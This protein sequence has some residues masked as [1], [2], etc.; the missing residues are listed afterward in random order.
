MAFNAGTPIESPKIYTGLCDFV[1]VAL[2]P[3]K[4]ELASLGINFEKEPSYLDKNSEGNDRIRLDFWGKVVI[5]EVISYKKVTFFIENVEKESQ[6]GNYQ[7]I[8]IYGDSAWGKDQETVL[9]SYSWFKANGVRKAKSGEADFITFIKRWL[10]IGRGQEAAI[11]NFNKLFSGNVDDF[12]TLLKVNKDRKLQVLLTVTE[13][14]DKYYQNIYN[15]YFGIAG[16]TNHTYWKK[17]FDS[18]TA[19]VNY[20]NSFSIKEFTGINNE[21]TDKSSSESN[22]TGG[23]WG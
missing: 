17:H 19:T 14:N 21:E 16:S 20:Q 11:D 23:F 1:P 18:N 7:F 15:K 8:N 10:S 4:E 3:T 2:N 6:S 22:S 12:K 9:A 5:N 13:S